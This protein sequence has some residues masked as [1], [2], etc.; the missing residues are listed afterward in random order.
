[1]VSNA[2]LLAALSLNMFEQSL[3]VF[4]VVRGIQLVEWLHR[5]ALPDRSFLSHLLAGVLK[6]NGSGLLRPLIAGNV[7]YSNKIG[8]LGVL[9]WGPSYVKWQIKPKYTNFVSCLLLA[10]Y[11][12]SQPL[13]LTAFVTSSSIISL[14]LST[15]WLIC[16]HLEVT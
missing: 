8:D 12:N 2:D 11:L 16:E 9:K 5:T 14:F 10:G 15:A 7:H 13:S 1:M 6:G 3:L 4:Q